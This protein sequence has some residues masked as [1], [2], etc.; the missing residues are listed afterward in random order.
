MTI[1]LLPTIVKT[2]AEAIKV[3]PTDY[4]AASLALGAS[5]TQTIFKVVLPNALPGL[6]TAVLLAIG[7]IIGESAALL[8]VLGTSIEDFPRMFDGST[9]LS[10]HIW[11]LT[12][13]EVPNFAAACSISMIIL[14]VVFVLSI[15]VKIT[16]HFYTKKR[17]A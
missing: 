15:L 12:Q 3:V 1:V 11:S 5:K 2:S 17:G 13:A 6:L 8:F 4:V 16:W 10:L 7:R 14:L 9:S